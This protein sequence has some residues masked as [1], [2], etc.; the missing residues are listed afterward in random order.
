MGVLSLS[1]LVT[2]FTTFSYPIVFVSVILGGFQG[3]RYFSRLSGHDI[4]DSRCQ[5]AMFLDGVG[6]FYRRVYV[7]LGKYQHGGRYIMVTI[8]TT[9]NGLPMISLALYSVTGANSSSRCVGS[10]YQG[11][12]YCGM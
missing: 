10:G 7:F 5:V 11:I 3:L 2:F 9:S 12:Y 8:T 1:L 4:E 6:Y